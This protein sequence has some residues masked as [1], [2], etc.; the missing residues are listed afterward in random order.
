M[1]YRNAA[2]LLPRELLA[3]VRKFHTGLLWIS[4][5]EEDSH[6][7]RDKKIFQMRRAGLL[8]S[9]I[10][11]ETGLSTRQVRRILNR[12]REGRT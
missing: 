1:R 9:Q 8:T 2:V 10:A 12:A 6:D 4:K 7:K 11:Q 5:G 3:R